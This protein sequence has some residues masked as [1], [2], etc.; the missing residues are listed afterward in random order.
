[1][2]V[3][4]RSA[5]VSPGFSLSASST[6]DD[7]SASSAFNPEAG[8]KRPKSLTY[9]GLQHGG[10]SDDEDETLHMFENYTNVASRP[11]H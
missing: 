9:A 5:A 11:S 4:T 3:V 6:S 10:Q 8:S 7:A 1:M 2:R